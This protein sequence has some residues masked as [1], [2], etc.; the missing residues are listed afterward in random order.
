[1]RDHVVTAEDNGGVHINS[2][3]PN[4]AFYLVAREAG[5]YAW[6]LPARIWYEALTSGLSA[7]TGFAG[8]AGATIAAAARLCG[9]GRRVHRLVAEAWG[10]VGVTPARPGDAA[11][12]IQVPPPLT[13]PAFRD[14]LRWRIRGGPSDGAH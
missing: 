9:Q 8:F 6:D 4:H 10:A 5:T 13:R 1:M 3:I 14:R 7:T 11:A 2:G 12:C